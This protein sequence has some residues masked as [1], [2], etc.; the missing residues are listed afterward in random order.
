MGSIFSSGRARLI[1][2]FLLIGCVSFMDLVLQSSPAFSQGYSQ[3]RRGG[4]GHI[5]RMAV[6]QQRTNVQNNCGFDGPYWHG[7]R[8]KHVDACRAERSGRGN[9][10]R[11]SIARFEKREARLRRCMVG[12]GG[13]RDEA[14]ENYA[15]AAITRYQQSLKYRCKLSNSVWNDNGDLHYNWCRRAS[16]AERTQRLNTMRLQIKRCKKR[17]GFR[18]IFKF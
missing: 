1:W 2:S 9:R 15:N 3:E 17:R 12:G 13:R 7:A 4:C 5:A 11:Y 6:Q 10:S 8:R 14:C 18:G 16:V